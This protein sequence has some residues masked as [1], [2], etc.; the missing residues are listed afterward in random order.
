MEYVVSSAASQGPG[1]LRDEIR[2]APV[3]ASVTFDLPPGATIALDTP[4][5]LSRT[6]N[7]LGPGPGELHLS[8]RGRTGVLIVD[9]GVSA[10]IAAMT[11]LDGRAV[12]GAAVDNFGR[13]QLHGIRFV[14]NMAQ[15]GGGAVY[16]RAGAS[17][18]VSQSVFIQNAAPNSHGGAIYND[19]GATLSPLQSS[20]FTRNAATYGSALFSAD[21]R[22]IGLFNDAFEMNVAG[23]TNDGIPGGGTVRV[24]GALT[25]RRST[26][27]RNVEGAVRAASVDASDSAFAG[28]SV[29]ASGQGAS[30]WGAAVLAIGGSQVSRISRCSFSGNEV[31]GFD[32]EGGAVFSFGGVVGDH[33]SFEDNAASTTDPGAF[34]R[35]GAIEARISLSLAH[36]SFGT[37]IARA[38]HGT[39]QGGAVDGG[40]QSIDLSTVEFVSNMA[41]GSYATGGA[42]YGIY[43]AKL[44]DV[45]FFRN[46]AVASLGD[47]NGGAASFGAG[48]TRFTRVRFIDNAASTNGGAVFLTAPSVVVQSTF[49]ENRVTRAFR[50]EGGGGALSLNIGATLAMSDSTVSRNTMNAEKGAIEFGPGGGGILTFA[51]ATIQNSTIAD[52]SSSTDGGGIYVKN[53]VGGPVTLVNATVYRNHAVRYG[54]NVYAFG[55]QHALALRNSILAGGTSRVGKDLWAGGGVQSYD[56]NLIEA[57][58]RGTLS[59]VTAHNLYGKPPGLLPLSNNGGPT[60]TN[61]DRSKSLVSGRIP[62]HGGCNDAGVTTDQRGY[63][64][65]GS[66]DRACDIGAFEHQ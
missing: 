59:G 47:G 25:V 32:P 16:N 64:R 23:S 60:Q 52:N 38:P 43:F 66:K 13:L 48:R 53:P 65:G 33:D 58:I 18:T 8:G 45:S 55:V 7:V 36:S 51:A 37:N 34:A 24:S 21:S 27:L 29:I 12:R 35:G 17:L 9:R 44:G 14:G 62:L 61:A 11:V 57:L 2:K 30:A 39:G 42:L 19:A 5:R 6:V 4:I 26:F 22:P 54:G 50:S 46:E 63:P 10:K 20:I 31:I 56:Y 49:D 15:A 1:T 3:G 40:N 41:T 28:N